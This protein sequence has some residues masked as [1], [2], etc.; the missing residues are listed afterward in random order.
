MTNLLV[1]IDKEVARADL[2]V[3]K[4]HCEV[5]M[6]TRKKLLGRIRTTSKYFGQ[7]EEG[8]L[9]PV[10]AVSSEEYGVI[11]GPCGQRDTPVRAARCYLRLGR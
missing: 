4:A 10:V 9:F 3:L 5:L 8:Q 2:V 6:D 11:G 7:G 1:K